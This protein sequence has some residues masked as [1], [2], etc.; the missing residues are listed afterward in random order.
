MGR[1]SWIVQMDPQSNPDFIFIRKM[2]KESWPRQKRRRQHENRGRR[3]SDVARHQRMPVAT[4]GQKRQGR[5]LCPGAWAGREGA[6]LSPGTQFSAVKM[7]WGF[8][9]LA[10]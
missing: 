1:S 4:S 2:P 6:S 3:W 9:P 7:I 5:G 8:R 10:L